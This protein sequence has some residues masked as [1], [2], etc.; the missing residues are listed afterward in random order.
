[1]LYYRM[2]ETEFRAWFAN[3]VTVAVANP[4][5]LS[6]TAGS[7]AALND[8]QTAYA[9][10]VSSYITAHDA[11]KIAT[12]DKNAAYGTAFALVQEWANLWQ[13]DSAVSD[14][15]KLELGLQLRDTTP[16]PRPLFAVTGFNVSGNSVG[17]VKMRWDS[18]GNL[19]GCTYFV[20]KSVDGGPWTFVTATSKTRFALSEQAMVPT[21]FRVRAERRGQFSD[22]SDFAGVYG[23][24]GG[25]LTLLEA[26]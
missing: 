18:N 15:L 17:T 24:T 26:A 3:F 16:H 9:A 25:G 11:A 7:I 12:N 13:V 20:E 5:P 2:T 14:A 1:M 22:P 8:A 23:A 21:L 19:P 4:V 6:L 10:A